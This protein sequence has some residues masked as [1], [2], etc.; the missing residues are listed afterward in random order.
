LI[1]S[2]GIVRPHFEQ[3]GVL[4]TDDRIMQADAA[5]SRPKPGVDEARKVVYYATR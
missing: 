5:L 4:I 1:S 3:V 2:L